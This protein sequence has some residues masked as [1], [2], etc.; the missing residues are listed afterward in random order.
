MNYSEALNLFGFTGEFT[1]ENLRK[2]IF[3]AF[4]KISSR[5]GWK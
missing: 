4:Q 3:R 5:Y 1:E 2:K